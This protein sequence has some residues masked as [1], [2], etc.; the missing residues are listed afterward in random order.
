MDVTKFGGAL[1][2]ASSDKL[3]GFQVK[4]YWKHNI[5]LLFFLIQMIPYKMVRQ[6]L[7]TI[8]LE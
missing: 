2:G 5:L 7:K 1:P 6:L 8:D 3:I 4:V